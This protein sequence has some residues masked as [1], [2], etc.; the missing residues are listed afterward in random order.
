M[1]ACFRRQDFAGAA[2]KIA[3]CREIGDG[4]DLEGLFQLYSERIRIVQKTPRPQTGME[5]CPGKQIAAV[6]F[7]VT[8]G[9]LLFIEVFHVWFI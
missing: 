6:N 8:F 4:F 9:E 5:F 7:S 3:R 2:R 1:I